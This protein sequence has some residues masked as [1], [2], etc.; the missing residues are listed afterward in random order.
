MKYTLIPLKRIKDEEEFWKGSRFRQYKIGLNLENK[1]DDF[2]EYMLTEIPGE[3]EYMVLTCVEGYKSGSTLA[4][5]KTLEDKSR[6]VVTAKAI[7]YSMGIENV[8]LKRE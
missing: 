7:K 4:L 8:Y 1:E 2:Y 5:V 3:K 6:F